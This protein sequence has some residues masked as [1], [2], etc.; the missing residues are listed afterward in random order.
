MPFFPARARATQRSMNETGT[1]ERRS[2]GLMR[3]SGIE[4]SRS[5]GWLPWCEKPRRRRGGKKDPT[6]T[7]DLVRVA[8]TGPQ[9]GNIAQGRRA[10]RATVFTTELRGA[11]LANLKGC[12]RSIQ[13]LREHQAPR[14]VQPQPFLVLQQIHAGHRSKMMMSGAGVHAGLSGE[15]FGPERFRELTRPKK[16]MGRRNGAGNRSGSQHA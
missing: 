16:E 14:F 12:A 5:R 6:E 1:T 4:K 15:G 11:L 3:M 9:A 7:Y 10:E 8:R 2:L 13:P